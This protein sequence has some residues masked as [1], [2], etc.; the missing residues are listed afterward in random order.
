MPAKIFITNKYAKLDEIL[1]TLF[2]SLDPK[3]VDKYED[4]RLKVKKSL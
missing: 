1:N 2:E 3:M 4:R